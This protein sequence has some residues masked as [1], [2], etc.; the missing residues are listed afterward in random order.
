MTVKIFCIYHKVAPIFKS[1]VIEPIQT[2]CNFTDLDLGIL[3]DNSG[4]N[5]GDKNPYYGEMTAWYWVWQNYLHE[6]PEVEYVGFCHY[7]RFL[8]FQQKEKQKAFSTK[9]SA[10]MLMEDFDKKYSN[11][12]ILPFIQDYDIVLPK[13]YKMKKKMGTIY[14]HYV[15]NHPKIEIEK[16]IN[17]IKEDY[18]EYVPDMEAYLNSKI[19]YFC[20]N[21]V[22]KREYFE[23][24]MSWV[25]D[26]LS[27]MD[28]ISDWTQYDEYLT[29]RTPAYLIERFINVWINYKIRVDNL[30]VLERKSFVLCDSM[31]KI[32]PGCFVVK[33][34]EHSIVNLFG[35]KFSLKN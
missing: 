1:D 29:Q 31:I 2:G 21:F 10:E 22:I 34:Q 19:G 11:E 26:L 7:R 32:F 16:F 30:K 15:N 24:L 20:L 13:K 9:I 23:E 18:P 14:E 6:H 25:F 8:D 5:I 17:L 4:V 3:K 27:K 33:N 12:K 35:L 28:K